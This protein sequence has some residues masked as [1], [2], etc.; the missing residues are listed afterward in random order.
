MFNKLLS[1]LG[2][3]AVCT[4]ALAQELPFHR[5]VNATKVNASTR[6]TELISYPS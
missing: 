3:A 2:L 1:T 6:R 4:L 5:D